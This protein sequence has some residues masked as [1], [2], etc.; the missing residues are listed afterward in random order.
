MPIANAD[1]RMAPVFVAFSFLPF[2]SARVPGEVL[3]LRLERSTV[4]AT[5]QPYHVPT[6]S[7]VEG[8][9]RACSTVPVLVARAGDHHLLAEEGALGADFLLESV[10]VVDSFG[11][12]QCVEPPGLLVVLGDAITELVTNSKIF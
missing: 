7:M 4:S 8:G 6:Q 3:S 10:Q 12:R 2:F 9:R 11:R 5:L 1:L